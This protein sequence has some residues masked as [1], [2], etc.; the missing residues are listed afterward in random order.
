MKKESAPKRRSMEAVALRHF[1]PKTK[2]SKKMYSRKL[3]YGKASR[4]W[5]AFDFLGGAYCQS[6]YVL[7][8]NGKYAVTVVPFP[9]LLATSSLPPCSSVSCF[10]RGKPRPV[11]SDFLDK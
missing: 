2:P 1:K 4:K 6:N 11:P 8:A 9:G 3:K 7:M 5:E 10:A